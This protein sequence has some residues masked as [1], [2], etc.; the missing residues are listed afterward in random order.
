MFYIVVGLI[1]QE[2]HLK[3]H[4]VRVPAPQSVMPILNVPHRAAAATGGPAGGPAG[5]AAGGGKPATIS[6]PPGDSGEQ[7][8][9]ELIFVSAEP[10]NAWNGIDESLIIG[11]FVWKCIPHLL[12]SKALK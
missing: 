6:R 9:D 4:K 2:N 7:E 5:S 1:N 12:C 8:D 11:I 3:V 10:G